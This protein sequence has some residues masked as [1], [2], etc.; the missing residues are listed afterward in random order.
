[1]ALLLELFSTGGL[2]LS[3]LSGANDLSTTVFPQF[4]I[5]SS[6]NIIDTIDLFGLEYRARSS[7]FYL[8]EVKELVE[9]ARHVE[10]IGKDVKSAEG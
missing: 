2:D 5:A 7:I 10:F 1:M 4:S 6:S 3:R 9:H 8:D